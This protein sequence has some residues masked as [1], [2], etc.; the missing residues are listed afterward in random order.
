MECRVIGMKNCAEVKCNVEI[1]TRKT[2]CD[3][4]ASE[5][6]LSAMRINAKNKRDAKR[7]KNPHIDPKW[8]VR[9]PIS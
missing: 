9:G 6:Q 1:V 5:R 8:L 3:K 4:C 7:K 2:Y